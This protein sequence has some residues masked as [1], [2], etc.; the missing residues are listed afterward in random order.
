MT[1]LVSL[2]L[3]HYVAVTFLSKDFCEDT[4]VNIDLGEKNTGQNCLQY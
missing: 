4:D 2:E 3:I 1:S